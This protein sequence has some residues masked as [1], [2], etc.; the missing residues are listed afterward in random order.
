MITYLT[1]N[2]GK[3]YCFLE[4]QILDEHAQFKEQGEFLYIQDAWCHKDYNLYKELFKIGYQL[5]A[6]SFT[7]G[8]KYIYWVRHK[9]DD[10]KSKLYT[11]EEFIK[12]FL[13]GVTNGKLESCNASTT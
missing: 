7:K 10:R 4:W 8:V 5:Y 3:I 13:K 9:Y 6:H 2:A 1:D 12:K 11:R